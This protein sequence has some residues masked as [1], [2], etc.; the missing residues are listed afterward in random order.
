MRSFQ[1]QVENPGVPLRQPAVALM[2]IDTANRTPGTKVNDLYINNQTTLVEGYFTRLALTELNMNWDIPNV[3]PYNN[4][5][6][7][8]FYWAPGVF[9]AVQF[10]IPTGFY[11]MTSLATALQTV[12]QADIAADPELAPNY[13]MTVTADPEYRTFT[14]QNTKVGGLDF[15][16]A[17]I[18][19]TNKN[20]TDLCDVMGLTNVSAS[21]RYTAIVSGY[22]T[23]LYTPYFDIVSK[24]L[25]KKQ[26][27][28]DNSTS[29]STGS[30][31]LARIYLT[32]FGINGNKV[33]PTTSADEE[34]NFILGSKPFTIHYEFQTPKQIYWDTKEFINVIDLSLVDNK[35]RIL[36]EIPTTNTPAVGG[37]ICVVGSGEANWQLTVQVTET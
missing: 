7:L 27:V 14:I 25:T 16:I 11:S 10:E 12:L 34:R 32:E 19:A 9:K 33:L 28:R 37:G 22:A 31:L 6:K 1:S 3:N 29:P 30:N 5:I 18:G 35:G 36:Y 4:T 23:M 13:T 15:G 8:V 24:Q 17:P 20:T 21:L 2:T 26:N